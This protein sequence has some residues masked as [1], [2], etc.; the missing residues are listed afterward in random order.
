MSKAPVSKGSGDMS[1]NM[2]PNMRQKLKSI[3]F[4]SA[5]G[6]EI[7]FNFSLSLFA[8]HPWG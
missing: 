2:S 6:S 4:Y 8:T 1:P 3:D 5:F 7:L